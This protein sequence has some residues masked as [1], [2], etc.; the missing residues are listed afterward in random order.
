[1]K[2]RVVSVTEFKA[3]CLSMLDEIEESGTA[4]TVTRRG[5]PVATL[6]PVESPKLKSP[7]NSLAGKVRIVGDIVNT[8]Y[9]GLWD[10]V[11][12]K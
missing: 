4:I 7:M 12:K 1:M 10:V 3:K 6:G 2:S 5:K 11:T 9:S 8:D